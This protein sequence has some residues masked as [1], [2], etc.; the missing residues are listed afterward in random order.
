MAESRYRWL[1]LALAAST[2]TLV[3]GM[4]SMSLPVLFPEI[5][6]EL[7]L[8]LVQVGTIW[9]IS[10]LTGI[11]MALMGGAIGDRFGAKRT[12]MIACLL[13]GVLGASRGFSTTFAA[14]TLT[15]LLAGLIP[16]AIPTNVHKTCGV[17]FSGRHLG[18]ANGVVSTGMALGFMLG[19]LLAASVLSPWLGGWRNVIF[20]YG[21]LAIG[22][23]ALWSLTRPAPAASIQRA[24]TAAKV[25]MRQGLAQV[26]RLRNV[27][28]LA[29]AMFGIGGC[30]QGALGYLPLYLRGIGWSGPAADSA[31]AMFHAVSMLCVLPIAIFSDR[32]G[33]RRSI[34][35][36]AGL[37]I[38]TGI[39]MLWFVSGPLVWVAIIVAGMV[40]DGF[41]A[42][43]MTFIIEIRGV[44]AG[45]AGTATGLIIASSMV[46]SVLSP[47]IGN[48]LA[49]IS[50]SLPFLFWSLLAFMGCVGIYL[51]REGA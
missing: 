28:L 16:S 3:M 8:N 23:A 18:L 1:I 43:L 40:R 27:R 20:F 45:W 39:G 42:V 35:L 31:L 7:S 36:I 32:L 15:T 26:S 6:A 22:V 21:A 44:G 17:W 19:S 29:V 2:M 10:S 47:P 46:A 11:V 24:K 33:V 25:S 12:L 48:S 51:T 4:P 13:T 5:A 30:I 38:A 37:M 14:L 49:S 34:L 50:P 9:G 41:M